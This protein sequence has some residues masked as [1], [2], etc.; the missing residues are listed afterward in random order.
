MS[1]LLVHVY[2]V[3]QQ[4]LS[5]VNIDTCTCIQLNYYIKEIYLSQGIESTVMLFMGGN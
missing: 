2:N 5:S 4:Y 3:H 1:I